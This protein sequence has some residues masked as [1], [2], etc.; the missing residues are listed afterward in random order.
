MVT[1]KRPVPDRRAAPR[2]RVRL[3]C[4][5]IF[6]GNEYEAIIRDISLLGAF[7]WSTFMPP[8]DATISIKLEPP[9]VE[10]PLILEGDVVRRD[11]RQMEQGAAGAFAITFSHNSPGLLRL[12]DKLISPKAP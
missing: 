2:V 7:L 4:Q 11:C 10:D 8:Q 5:V 12:I 6:D 3:G 9:F 1:Q